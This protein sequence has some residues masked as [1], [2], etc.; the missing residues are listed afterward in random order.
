MLKFWK[1]A[2]AATL[3]GAV[4]LT[5]A[6]DTAEAGRRHRNNTGKFI[7]GVVTGLV[8]G[9][10]LYGATRPANGAVVY[11]SYDEP[12]CYRGPRQ[13]ETHWNC[14]INRWNREVCEKAV[15]CQRPLICE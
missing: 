10:L 4:A 15:S 1:P 3:I 8:A 11:E 14:W 7:G 2:L 6:I 9:A 13:C 5:S 12:V